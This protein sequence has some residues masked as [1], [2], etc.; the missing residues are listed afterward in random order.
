MNLEMV[1]VQNICKMYKYSTKHPGPSGCLGRVSC[2][3]PEPS[4]GMQHLVTM[5]VICWNKD[6]KYLKSTQTV[7]SFQIRAEN[8]MMNPAVILLF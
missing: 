2:V 5:L 8:M 3:F 4:K 1:L 6:P 7:S